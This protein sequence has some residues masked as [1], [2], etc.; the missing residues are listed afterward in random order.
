MPGINTA[1]VAGPA[2]T[3][4]MIGRLIVTEQNT[5]YKISHALLNRFIESGRMEERKERLVKHY[6][7]QRD[8]MYSRLLSLKEYGLSF[9]KPEGGLY[10]WCKLP[11]DI[12]EKKLFMTSGEKG[13]LYMPGSV[14]FPYGYSGSGYIRLC[15][16][17]VSEQDIDRSIDILKDSMEISRD[18][19]NN[20][21]IKS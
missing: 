14:F 16:S 1:F 8:M 10:I 20:W 12:N 2:E 11:E 13:L 21:K 18:C 4:E 5:I 15:F 6:K 7:K 19:F 3:V 17:N 9:E